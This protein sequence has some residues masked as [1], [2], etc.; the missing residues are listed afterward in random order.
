MSKVSADQFYQQ[1][2]KDPEL[3]QKF[4]TVVGRENTAALAVELGKE[5]G[6]NFTVEEAME[7]INEWYKPKSQEQELSDE[8]LEA[9]AGGLRSAFTDNWGCA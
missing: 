6:Y 1:I 2:V 7:S 3:Q 9:V 5:K 8:Q 4:Q